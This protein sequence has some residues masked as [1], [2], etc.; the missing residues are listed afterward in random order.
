MDNTC[1]A[2]ADCIREYNLPVITQHFAPNIEVARQINADEY[3]M[4]FYTHAS[5]I[6]NGLVE[7]WR[8]WLQAL[9]PLR[10]GLRI[11]L[12]EYL[13]PESFDWETKQIIRRVEPAMKCANRLQDLA[14]LEQAIPEM[15]AMCTEFGIEF[16]AIGIYPIGNMWEDEFQRDKTGDPDDRNGLCDFKWNAALR[17]QERC[18]VWPLIEKC[19]SLV[20][21]ES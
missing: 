10:K 13:I 8:Q 19:R 9:A 12:G 18:L 20:N 14:A 16:T 21:R 3:W 15:K 7:Y 17:K 11:G 1:N 6:E 5:G 4:D 2:L